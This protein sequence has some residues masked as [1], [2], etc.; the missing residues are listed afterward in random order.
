MDE[1]KR[2]KKVSVEKPI[3]DDIEKIHEFFL[4]KNASLRKK[5][6]TYLLTGAFILVP[7][8]L[9]LWGTW[10]IFSKLTDWGV[11]VFSSYCADP[12]IDYWVSI[13]VRMFTLVFI[14]AVLILIGF[15]T[16]NTLAQKLGQFAQF[17]LTKI[18]LVNFIYKIVKQITDAICNHDNKFNKVLLIE[19]PRKGIYTIA[20]LANDCQED[21]ELKQL[22][23]KDLVGVF[24]P[25]TP[26]PTSGFLFYVPREECHELQMTPAEAM[27]LIISCGA[28]SPNN[29][30]GNTVGKIDIEK[31]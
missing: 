9:A 12:E 27:S 16:K 1:K 11:D 4:Q 3:M 13:L 17:F 5:V 29:I 2:E 21:N 24:I 23:G 28:I 30:K 10:F 26:N 22:T 6:Q 7:V 8:F 15:L 19:Y 14:V 31:Q 18:P 20:F 25:T